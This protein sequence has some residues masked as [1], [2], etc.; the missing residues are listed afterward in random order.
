VRLAQ[1]HFDQAVSLARIYDSAAAVE[2]G[3]LDEAVPA[4]GLAARAADMAA[5]LATLN[6]EA[7]RNTKKRVRELLSERLELAL[8]RDFAAAG[9][10]AASS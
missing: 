10:Q 1:R 8:Q 5:T 9:M 4:D 6:M 2:A 7:H 3:F